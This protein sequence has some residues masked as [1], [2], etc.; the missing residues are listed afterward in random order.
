MDTCK[1][2]PPKGNVDVV[3]DTDA[4]NEIDDQFAIAW[5][6][7][8]KERLNTVALYA[9]PFFNSKSESPSDGMQ[10]SYD[11][12]FHILNLCGEER[13]VFAGSEDYLPND[14][15]PVP[16]PAAED[17]IER[18]MIYSADKPLY[19]VAIGAITNVASALLM[20]PEI[21]D[22]IVVVWLGG[23]SHDWENTIE[24]NM[25]QDYAAA[26]AVMSSG[27]PF[28][29]LPCRGVV[30]YFYSTEPELR[31]WLSGKNPLAD[32]LA[33]NTIRYMS[34]QAGTPWTKVIWDVTAVAW[35]M[36]EDER[37][38]FSESQKRRLSDYENQYEQPLEQEMEYVYH[39]RRN[40]LMDDMLRRILSLG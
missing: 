32:Y 12:I 14:T 7:R 34:K 37:Y 31:Y 30:D 1:L 17:L 6:L 39:I 26:R 25:K 21:K 18:A 29:Q 19:V 24:F 8:S 40:E 10:K 35:L 9:A 36:N 28:I 33:E 16:S 2:L 13:P 3:L 27:V 15:T 22:R 38:M 11:E 20:K 5:L 23:N 4:Y